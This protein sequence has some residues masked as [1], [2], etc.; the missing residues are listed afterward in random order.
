[1]ASRSDRM[2]GVSESGLLLPQD[3]ADGDR[4]FA[5]ILRPRGVVQVERVVR[6]QEADQR[7]Q[8]Q[9]HPLLAV[10][11]AVREADP[12]AGR[13]QDPAHPARG[14]VPLVGRVIEPRLADQPLHRQEQARRGNEA[15][16]RR[17]Q[18]REPDL[19]G[20]G[21]VHA[22]DVAPREQAIGQP[23][24][25]DRADQGVRARDRQP[26]PPGGEVPDHPGQQEREHHHDGADRCA[27]DQQVDRQEVARC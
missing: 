4:G 7:Q 6:R 1:M 14:S 11:G 10:V 12:A 5:D 13:Q 19:P 3:V 18:E 21:P 24:P 22:L 20:L 2:A 23:D 8:D 27:V 15:E 26:V 9:P 16:D 17:D 25:Q